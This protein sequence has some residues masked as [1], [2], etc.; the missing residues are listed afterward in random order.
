MA[1][2][3]LHDLVIRADKSETKCTKVVWL[4][5]WVMEQLFKKECD[6]T[7]NQNKAWNKFALYYFII[8]LGLALL[9]F[10]LEVRE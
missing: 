2:L 9:I 3:L 7:T 10:F 8:G 1:P 6:L 4:V 5:F